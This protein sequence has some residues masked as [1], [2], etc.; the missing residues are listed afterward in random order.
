MISVSEIAGKALA[1]G[2]KPPPD[3]K[4]ADWADEYRILSPEASAE[5]GRWRTARAE[6]LRDIMNTM[7]ERSIESIV[8][9]SSSQVGKTEIILN[10][11]GYNI[12]YVPSPMLVL[13]PTLDLAE[14]FAK[15]RLSPMCRDTKPL[16]GKIKDARARDSGNTIKHKTFPGGH[17]TMAGANSPASLSSRPIRVLLC[18]E[19]DRYPRSAG[20]EGD[21]VNL[22]RKRT[23]TF[24][25]RKILLMS[26]P[27]I[28]GLSRIEAAYESSDQRRFFV[29]CPHCGERQVLKW[30][31]VKWEKDNRKNVWYECESCQKKIENRDKYRMI[32]SGKWRA[33]ATSHDGKTAGFHLNELYSPWKTWAEVVNDFFDAK[34]DPEMLK[35]WVNT[36]LG[37]SWEEE[38]EVINE[39]WEERTEEY[40]E[41]PE[42]VIVLTAGVDVQDNRI[43]CEIVGWGVGEESW[44]IDYHVIHGSPEMQ[45]TWDSLDE[46][47]FRDYSHPHGALHVKCACV[48]SGG[49]HTDAVYRYVKKREIR[50]IYAIKGSSTPASPLVRKATK[51]NK[52]RVSLF[53]VGTDTAKE[54]IFS[55]L[56]IEDH[57]PGYCHFPTRYDDEFFAQLTGEKVVTKYRHGRPYREWVKIR[58]RNEALDCRVYALAALKILNPQLEFIKR[59]REQEKPQNETPHQK[60]VK[61]YKLQKRTNFVKNW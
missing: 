2:L 27:T 48:D 30:A 1:A 26:T 42:P 3:L 21:P 6:Y 50:R 31:Q 15:D 14:T 41:V 20:A 8:L 43:E 46:V 23:T 38:G 61:T 56:K 57:G 12:D 5:P 55:R 54:V 45:A 52:M 10:V 18:D 53:P 51:S 44:S 58:P 24:Y 60:P 4:V 36:S 9:M 22:A 25:N 49:H 29:P 32:Q 11:I 35:T 33:T 17:I 59:R 13:L 47:L 40:S 28:K 39:R 16:Q 7:N 37:E 19:V 34:K